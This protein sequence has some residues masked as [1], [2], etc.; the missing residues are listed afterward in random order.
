MLLLLS[1]H[2]S[3]SSNRCRLKLTSTLADKASLKRCSALPNTKICVTLLLAKLWLGLK[4]LG[5]PQMLEL[6]AAS[7]AIDAGQLLVV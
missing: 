7:S 2:A 4:L 6:S 1:P 3:T 5:R